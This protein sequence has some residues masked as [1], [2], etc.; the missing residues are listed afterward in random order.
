[1]PLSPQELAERAAAAMLANDRASRH[2]GIALEEV[3][4]GA[5]TL[6][7]TVADHHLNGLDVCHGGYIFSLA[8]TAMAF[9]SNSY[10][11]PALAQIAQVSFLAPA[12]LGDRLTAIATEAA[13]PG[14]TGVYDVE[15]RNQAGAQIALFRGH[16]EQ[17]WTA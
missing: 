3:S 7:M 12:R 1:M 17:E 9:A 4:P 15:V 6:G 8:D 10:N 13:R 2:I 14:R 5:A 11:T 16:S